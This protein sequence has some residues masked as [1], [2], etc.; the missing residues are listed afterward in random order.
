MAKYRVGNEYFTY[1]INGWA[2]GINYF[3]SVG[4]FTTTEWNRLLNGEV[5]TKNGNDF[6]I[7]RE[8][9]Y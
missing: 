5:V 8:E 7:L 4:S 9:V 3:K 2:E 6:Y 1:L